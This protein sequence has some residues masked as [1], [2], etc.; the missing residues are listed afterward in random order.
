MKTLISGKSSAYG[1]KSSVK[2]IQ[3]KWIRKADLYS[4]EVEFHYVVNV[5]SPLDSIEIIF[6]SSDKNCL[7]SS[8]VC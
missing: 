5:T 8:K 7:W 6:E 3:Q 1:L 4:L 2:K